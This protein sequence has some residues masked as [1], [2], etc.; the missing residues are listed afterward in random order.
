M[1]INFFSNN[2][3]TISDLK[4]E[5]KELL[6]KYHPDITGGDGE[7]MKI[8]NSEYDYL[9]KHISEENKEDEKI[10]V[11]DNFKEVL[12]KLIKYDLT[13]EIVGSWLWISGKDTFNLKDNLFKELNIFYS[14]GKKKFFYN[15]QDSKSYGHYRKKSFKE[16][17]NQ[18]GYKKL[19]GQKEKELLLS[20]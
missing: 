10:N 16:L 18:Y 11:N 12:N 4:K 5:Y 1:K 3:K 2:L 20:R 19:Q 6:F 17:K 13:L 15:G 7:E 14:R 9:L 8:I